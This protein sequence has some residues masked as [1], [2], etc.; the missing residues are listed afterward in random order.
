MGRKRQRARLLVYFEPVSFPGFGLK[1]VCGKKLTLVL[2]PVRCTATKI[3]EI[4]N[5]EGQGAAFFHLLIN[6]RSW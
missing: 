4:E 2:T 1:D 6:P 3:E 5:A